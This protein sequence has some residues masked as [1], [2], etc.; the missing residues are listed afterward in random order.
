MAIQCVNSGSTR[1]PPPFRMAPGSPPRS[2]ALPLGTEPR[3]WEVGPSALNTSPGTH[4]RGHRSAEGDG[5]NVA[6]SVETSLSWKE[7]KEVGKRIEPS[8]NHRSDT[9]GR[10]HGAFWKI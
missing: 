6:W 5:C 9:S 1:S 10:G 8:P 4:P 2:P 3:A 7:Q